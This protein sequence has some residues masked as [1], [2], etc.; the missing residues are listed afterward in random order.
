[1]ADDNP[2]RRISLGNWLTIAVIVG[3]MGAQ[4]FGLQRQVELQTKDMEQLIYRVDRLEAGN[5]SLEALRSSTTRLT[6]QVDEL[7]K[8]VDRLDR[9][10]ER[11]ERNN[12]T[13]N[14]IP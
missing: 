14:G 5:S 3:G 1:M 10:L 2:L 8:V 12:R 7:L 6:V 9:R 4:W 11:Q 13:P